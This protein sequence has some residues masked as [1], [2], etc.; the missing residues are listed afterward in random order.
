MT[1][2]LKFLS[3][4]AVGPY[5]GF[6]WPTPK[7]SKPGK[8][9]KATGPLI[10]CS[11]GIHATTLDHA[12]DWLN[13][14]CYVI[15]LHGESVEADNKLCYR[16]GRL[17]RRVEEWNEKNARLFAADC[18]MKVLPIYEKRHPDDDRPRKAIHAARAYAKHPTEKNRIRMAAAGAAAGAATWAATRDTARDTARAAAWAA[19]RYTAWAAAG[20]TAWAAAGAATWDT[21]RDTARA[22]AWA[23]AWAA[24]GAWQTK[25]L[26]HY[27]GDIPELT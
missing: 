8:W 5:S 27:L 25:R 23:A 3:E 14:E 20:D 24:A 11:N 1:H 17:V 16:E 18:A 22:A 15:E 13:A 21:A 9:V 7:G 12:L 4:G 10:A 6:K 19:T 26:A 2:A